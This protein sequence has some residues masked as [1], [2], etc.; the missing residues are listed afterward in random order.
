MSQYQVPPP[1]TRVVIPP[2][3]IPDTNVQQVIVSTTPKPVQRGS[4]GICGYCCGCMRIV[5]GCLS[6]PFVCAGS[7]LAGTGFTFYHIALCDINKREVLNKRD[8][9]CT[10]CG[11]GT[12]CART[13]ITVEQGVQD[14]RRAPNIIHEM[15]RK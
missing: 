11:C 1:I 8:S 2:I 10:C 12:A 13:C 9:F 4:Y 5:G 14:I 15:T 3:I 7:C 6:C